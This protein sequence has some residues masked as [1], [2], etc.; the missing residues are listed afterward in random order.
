MRP[1]TTLTAAIALV[2]AASGCSGTS[3]SDNTGRVALKLSTIPAGS[4]G[5][6]L[7]APG[8]SVTLGA[9]VIL[10]ENVELVARKIKLQRVNG[11]CP[12]PVVDETSG[13]DAD[14]AGTDECPNLRL[15]P[16]VIAPPLIAG[17]SSS[18]TTDVPIG[19]YDKMTLQIHKPTGSKDAAFLAAN[20][21][22]TGISIRVTGT[23]NS[24]PFTF[25]TPLTS[26]VEIAFPKVIEVNGDDLTELTLKVDVRNWF[27]AEGGGSLLNPLT[28][29]Q[30]GRSR[31]EQS[32][33]ASFKVFE[34]P[35][36]DGIDD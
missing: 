22:F 7:M 1:I 12:A 36:E 16:M 34:D 26:V 20:P 23:F 3:S 11:S 5:A 18:F 17:V 25:V 4:S 35:D 32:I 13:T 21:L 19:T 9:D 27:L 33:R 28:L 8:L 31:I 10:I 15:G 30:Q 14:E 24:V 2:V 6:S 29:T